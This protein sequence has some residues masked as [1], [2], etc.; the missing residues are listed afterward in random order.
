VLALSGSSFAAFRFRNLLRS[1]RFR[2]YGGFV[3]WRD[4][5]VVAICTASLCIATGIV[6]AF[7]FNARLPGLT[8]DTVLFG[9]V[10]SGSGP[11][12][13]AALAFAAVLVFRIRNPEPID[14]AL[15]LSLCA[16]VLQ[17]ALTFAGG[18]QN[19]IATYCARLSFLL[20]SLFVLIS[21]MKMLVA[22]HR[23]IRN[24]ESALSQV[25]GESS[26]RAGRIRALLQISAVGFDERRFATIL[27]IATTAIRPG[28]SILGLLSHLE[29]DTIIIDATSWT[30]KEEAGAIASAVHVGSIFPF[31]RTLQSLLGEDRAQYH[32][33]CSIASSK[34]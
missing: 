6:I 22:S 12:S 17:I 8:T 34:M 4:F 25:E 10:S 21:V 33:G 1:R 20:A 28:R 31:N 14:V 7:V 3:R 23:R 13:V 18:Q 15:A 11:F 29:G 9:A 24:V 5:T 2:Y 26:K 27:R 32:G 30:A 19:T 16:L